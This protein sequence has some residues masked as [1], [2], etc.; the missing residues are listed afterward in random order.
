MCFDTNIDELT[1]SDVIITNGKIR[2]IDMLIMDQET[3]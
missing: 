3:R 1:K 2:V